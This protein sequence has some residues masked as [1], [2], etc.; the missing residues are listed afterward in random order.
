KVTESGQLAL[1]LPFAVGCVVYGLESARREGSLRRADIFLALFAAMGM[2]AL[3]ITTAFLP[4][5][6]GVG[7]LSTL[8]PIA[9]GVLLL[10]L[11]LGTVRTAR[12]PLSRYALLALCIIL[13]LLIGALCVNLKRGPWAG[14]LIATIIYLLFLEKRLIPFTVL[15][16][17]L[18][19]FFIEPVRE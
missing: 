17:A 4:T 2:A 1:V 18:V 15:G 6:T 7:A 5:L 10:A 16:A 8:L 3:S 12:S 13:P 11:A 9:W 19:I 14:V